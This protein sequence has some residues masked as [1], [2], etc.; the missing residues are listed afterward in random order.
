MENDRKTEDLNRGRRENWV[1]WHSSGSGLQPE[2][3]AQRNFLRGHQFVLSFY[4]EGGG[5][6]AQ[7]P[8]KYQ[9]V[10]GGPVNQDSDVFEKLVDNYWRNYSADQEDR[11]CPRETIEEEE[12][13]SKVLIAP[14]HKLSKNEITSCSS[15]LNE[16]GPCLH[17]ARKFTFP[18]TVSL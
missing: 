5:I 17:D 12:L 13:S 8:G 9:K 18:A 1:G 10:Y 7:Y 3:I 15:S 4:L 11:E 2:V 16:S 14:N 6:G